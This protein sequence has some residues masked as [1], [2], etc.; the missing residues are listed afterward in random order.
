MPP[1]IFPLNIFEKK[2]KIK[3]REKTKVLV[4]LIRCDLLCKGY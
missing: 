2:D 3:K 4:G 1:L